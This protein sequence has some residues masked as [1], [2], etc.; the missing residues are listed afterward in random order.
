MSTRTN[1]NASAKAR[2]AFLLHSNALDPA[3]RLAAG[4]DIDA[5]ALPGLQQ[6]AHLQGD[7]RA[8]NGGAADPERLGQ[9]ALGSQALARLVTAVG[10]R[11]ADVRRHALVEAQG[12]GGRRRRHLRLQP[13]RR[14]YPKRR[15][16]GSEDLVLRQ[17]Q[18][19]VLLRGL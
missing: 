19:E 15:R 10:D 5:R 1:Q 4:A 16:G 11:L 7:H 6:A 18:D 3:W 17:A 2:W 8:A 13:A 14:R 12:I 9:V